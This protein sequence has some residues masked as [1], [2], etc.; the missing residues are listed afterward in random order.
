MKK[1]LAVIAGALAISNMALI[2]YSRIQKKSLKEV[3]SKYQKF[4]KYYQVYNSWIFNSNKKISMEDLIKKM[5]LKNIAIYGCGEMGT[6]LYESLSGTDIQVKFFIDKTAGDVPMNIDDMAVYGIDD[7]EYLKEIDA[8]IV[9][10][11]FQFEEI[12]DE[13]QKV[14]SDI[15]VYSIEDL[16]GE[17]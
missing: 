3:N 10:P 6:R 14:N 15:L 11:V 13:L 12:V 5:N 16:F 2:V 4:K 17:Q 9:T 8:I 7:G 1:I